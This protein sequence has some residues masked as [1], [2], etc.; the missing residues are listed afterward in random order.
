M[1]VAGGKD[2]DLMA[3]FRANPHLLL[4]IGFYAAAMGRVKGA[5]INDPQLAPP[6][7]GQ[8]CISDAR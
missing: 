8:V 1:P 3:Q 6:V 7:A 2:D 4:D 5:N